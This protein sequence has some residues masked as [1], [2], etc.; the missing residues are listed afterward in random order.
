M[1][2]SELFRNKLLNLLD[3]SS[4]N[5][6]KY[7]LKEETKGEITMGYKEENT[8]ISFADTALIK[9]ME[10]NRSL[11]R[12]EQI[13]KVIDWGQIKQQL[14]KYYKTGK[15]NEGAD[16]YPPLVLLKGL[17]LQKWYKIES[18]PELENQIN[19]RISFKKFL[20]MSL[21][22]ESPDH[23]TFSRFRS[24]LS[25]EAMMKINNTVLMQFTKRGLK[26]NEYPQGIR[27]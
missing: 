3:K 2:K 12:L 23:S 17:L 18:D 15:S 11:K 16:A 5:E 24:R 10:K 13:N 26:I 6:I 7:P 19:D 27:G 1:T 22:K 8:H 14:K 25:K 9:S 4:G 20:G 21:D